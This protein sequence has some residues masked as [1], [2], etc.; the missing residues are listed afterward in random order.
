ML[1][2]R[3]NRPLMVYAMLAAHKHGV[4]GA[5]SSCAAPLVLNDQRHHPTIGF[6]TYK[7]G[8]VPA[9]ASSAVAAA[10]TGTPE[11]PTANAEDVVREALELGYRFL[12]CAEFYGNEA[13]VGRGIAASGVPRGELYLASKAWTSTIYAGPDAVQAQLEQS[14]RDLGTDYLDLYLARSLAKLC[15]SL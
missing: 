15:P 4:S 11:A 5:A 7:V 2:R 9:S 8:G 13:A 6:G 12:D 3:L 10:A 1:V 14:L